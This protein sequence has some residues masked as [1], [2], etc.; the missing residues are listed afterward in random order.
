M[1]SEALRKASCSRLFRILCSKDG[2]P[3]FDALIDNDNEGVWLYFRR[4]H[5]EARK[6]WLKSGEKGPKQGSEES[7]LKVYILCLGEYLKFLLDKLQ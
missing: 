4:P 5:D 2:S 3:N 1:E 6:E 7:T